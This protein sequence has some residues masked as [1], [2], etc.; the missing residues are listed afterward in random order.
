M[1]FLFLSVRP[2][3]GADTLGIPHFCWLPGRQTHLLHREEPEPSGLQL[4]LPWGAREAGGHPP[5]AV[6]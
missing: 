1:F 6:F 4:V 2:G 3:P 5:G